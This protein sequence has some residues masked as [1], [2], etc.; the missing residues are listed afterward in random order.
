MFSRMHAA[1]AFMSRLGIKW[2]S[3]HDRDIAP[4]G[5]TWTETC[6]NL[7]E[8]G[9]LAKSLMSQHN[10]KLLWA[11]ANLFTHKRYA[12]GALTNPDAHVVAFAGAQVWM[13]RGRA[14]VSLD[15]S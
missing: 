1:F 4:E 12:N 11:T 6:Q 8:M 3:M 14:A 15:W 2:W 7:T 13:D 10:I 5:K 9:K